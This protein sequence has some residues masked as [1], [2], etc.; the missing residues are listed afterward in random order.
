MEHHHPTT[1][2]YLEKCRE[3]AQRH[4]ADQTDTETYDKGLALV[5]DAAA[6]QGIEQWTPEHTAGALFVLAGVKA[7]AERLPSALGDVVNVMAEIQEDG[8]VY[9]DENP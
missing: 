7:Q 1:Q 3:A 5:K 6:Q 2:E 8:I 9:L 4:R